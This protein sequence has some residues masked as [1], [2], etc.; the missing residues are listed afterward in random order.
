MGPRIRRRLAV[1][2]LLALAVAAARY[3]EAALW[4]LTVGAR[5]SARALE[6]TASPLPTASRDVP[7]PLRTI[8][9]PAAA[10]RLG[11]RN[12]FTFA[13]PS[14]SGR[15]APVTSEPEVAAPPAGLQALPTASNPMRLVGI[16]AR[17]APDGPRRTA[18]ISAFGELWLLEAGEALT[19]RYRIETVG[20]TSVALVD[21]ATGTTLTLILR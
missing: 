19:G 21:L 17:D 6:S 15:E 5:D 2:A 1:G 11:G 14:P 13:V 4:W 12:P 16:A 10:P 18:V 7:P 20:E 9:V 3:G 8:D